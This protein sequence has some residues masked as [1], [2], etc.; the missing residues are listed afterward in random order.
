MKTV[1]KAL[2]F[3]VKT[4]QKEPSVSQPAKPESSKTGRQKQPWLPK[5]GDNSGGAVVLKNHQEIDITFRD[6]QGRPKT[7]KAWVPILN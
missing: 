7:T 3:E 6:A 4:V 1:E 5:K 2:K